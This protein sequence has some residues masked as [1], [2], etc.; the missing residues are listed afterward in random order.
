[1]WWR[2]DRKRE[3]QGKEHQSDNLGS[4]TKVSNRRGAGFWFW[5][6]LGAAAVC[7]PDVPSLFLSLSLCLS[8]SL[9]L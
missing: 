9:S 5:V 6:L 7:A 3:Q 4:E 1:M 8:V 2:R